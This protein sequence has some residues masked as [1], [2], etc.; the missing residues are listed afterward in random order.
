MSTLMSICDNG[1]GCKVI[2][3]EIRV[4]V[5]TELIALTISMIIPNRN[6]EHLILYMRKPPFDSVG[7]CSAL[8]RHVRAYFG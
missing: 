5:S 7:A 8:A 3:K 4:K 1:M 6:I 2:A